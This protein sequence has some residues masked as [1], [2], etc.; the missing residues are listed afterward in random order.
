MIELQ[1]IKREY[2]EQIKI[3]LY[4]S[5]DVGKSSFLNRLVYNK[6]NLAKTNSIGIEI[7]SRIYEA[8]DVTFKVDIWDAYG[9]PDGATKSSV[10]MKNAIGMI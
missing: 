10:Y 4:G 9:G 2:D 5:S 1:E 3:I 8:A 7:G 6:F